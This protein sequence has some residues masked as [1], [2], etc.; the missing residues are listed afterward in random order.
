MNV[1]LPVSG[2]PAASIPLGRD[3][4]AAILAAANLLLPH[5]ERGAPVDTAMLRAA[6]GSG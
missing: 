5:L 1:M 4:A 6:R 3:P 2:L